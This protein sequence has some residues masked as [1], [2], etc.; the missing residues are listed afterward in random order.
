MALILVFALNSCK[1]DGIAYGGDYN[2]SLYAWREFKSTCGNSY[3]YQVITNSWAGYATETIITVKQGK[4]T[5]RSYVAK[6]N[7]GNGQI[8]VL[9]EWKED[10]TQLGTHDKGAT[11]L[12]MDEVY[13]KAADDWLKK[14][15]NAN[16]SFE[17]KN[18]GMISL[19]GY[20][21]KGCQD[22]CFNGIVIKYIRAGL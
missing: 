14:R 11:L 9:Q 5:E 7:D 4:I 8:T 3:S 18:N 19:C 6:M 22:D 1:K 10:E 16:T 2:I 15:D 20:G 13:A 21:M 12:T 17:A